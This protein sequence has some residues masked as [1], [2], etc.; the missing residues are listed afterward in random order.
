MA[1]SQSNTAP[2]G[3]AMA[4][5][6]LT[7]AARRVFSI[8]ESRIENEMILK[9]QDLLVVLKMLARGRDSAWTYNGLAV[10]LGMSPSEVHAGVKRAIRARLARADGGSCPARPVVRP[11]EEFVFYGVP[12]VFIPDQGGETRGIPT[13]WA[14][15]LLRES[16]VGGSAPPPVWPHPE[17]TSRGY[18]FSP[19]YRAAPEAALRDERLY[20]L[21]T[22][23]DVFRMGRAREV[24]MARELFRDLIREYDHGRQSEH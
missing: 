20:N 13:A 11:V 21:L 5:Y 16:L 24:K 2:A 23:L 8:R 18:E 9:P 19:L 12:H 6:T 7:P 14:A 17:G 1:S 10:E 4:G 15:P 3:E 22:L